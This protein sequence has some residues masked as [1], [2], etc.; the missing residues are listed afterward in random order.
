MFGAEISATSLNMKSWPVSTLSSKFMANCFV[1]DCLGAP[2]IGVPAGAG[3]H[4]AK[5]DFLRGMTVL[6]AWAGDPLN[7]WIITT[8][9]SD[10]AQLR[11]RT[12]LDEAAQKFVLDNQEEVSSAELEGVVLPSGVGV[13]RLDDELVVSRGKSSK[14]VSGCGFDPQAR[15]VQLGSNLGLETD[16]EVVKLSLS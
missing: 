14:Q 6:N 9:R 7:V 12:H 13:L 3:L 16:R 2:F 11:L 1:Q 5:A 4:Q 10:G 8:R 15:L